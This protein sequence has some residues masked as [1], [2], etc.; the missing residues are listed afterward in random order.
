MGKLNSTSFDSKA[1]E[2]VKAGQFDSTCGT[3]AL[4]EGAQFK[5]VGHDSKH[6]SLW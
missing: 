4:A 2:K 3:R 6:R 5:V 1:A